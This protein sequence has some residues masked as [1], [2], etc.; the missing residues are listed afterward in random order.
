MLAMDLNGGEDPCNSS[1]KVVKI[2]EKYEL[3]KKQ[4]VVSNVFEP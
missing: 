4:H 1:P 3:A 2:Q